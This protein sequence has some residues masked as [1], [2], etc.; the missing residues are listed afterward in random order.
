M[1]LT[2]FKCNLTLDI[3]SNLVLGGEVN[4]FAKFPLTLSFKINGNVSN[5]KSCIETQLNNVSLEHKLDCRVAQKVK[6]GKINI[7]TIDANQQTKLDLTNDIFGP[8]DFKY[9]TRKQ[10]DELSLRLISSLS[11]YEEYEFS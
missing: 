7:L 5:F 8:A 3:C 6:I 4:N 11:V 1:P 9:V 2:E 10:L